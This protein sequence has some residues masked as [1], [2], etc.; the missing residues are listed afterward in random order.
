MNHVLVL[1]LLLASAAGAHAQAPAQLARV[2]TSGS[3]A[4]IAAGEEGR[5]VVEIAPTGTPGAP[6]HLETAFPTRVAL[7]APAGLRLTK[8]RFAKADAAQMEQQRIRFE[9]PF[10][11][12]A[13]GRQEI[14]GRV[15]F[16][17]CVEDPKTRAT[18][19]CYPQKR[20]IAHA[21]VVK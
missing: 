6:T 11:A 3:T 9:V 14:K 7:A 17:V 21:V 5:L 16:A 19:A 8:D 12:S 1:G 4:E 15:D 20:E 10:T 2:D 18:V 13:R